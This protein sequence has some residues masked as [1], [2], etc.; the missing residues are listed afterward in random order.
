MIRRMKDFK[1][2]PQNA[3]YGTGRRK[4]SIARVWL[5]KD[6]NKQIV[7]AKDSGKEFEL[8]DYV[9]RE[10]L[11]HKVLHPLKL[12]GLEGRFGIYATVEGGGISAQAEALMYG[13]AKAIINYNSELRS[14]LKKAGLLARDAREK[15]RKKYGLM[16]ARKAYRWSKR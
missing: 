3:F 12:S 13:I 7:K 1:I 8:K 15:E 9:Q 2:V 6:T 16:K 4:E 5:V 11:Y 10:S 14:T